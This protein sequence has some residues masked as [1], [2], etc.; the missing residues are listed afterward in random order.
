MQCGKCF[1][2]AGSLRKHERI[3]TGEKPCEYKECGKCF[4]QKGTLRRHERAHTG[5]KPTNVNSV[6]SVLV[7]H[8]L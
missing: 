2:E 3:R 1:S 6:A 4:I 5:E 7:E 8:F